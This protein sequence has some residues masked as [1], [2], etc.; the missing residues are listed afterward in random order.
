[1]NN[2]AI[3]KDL[4]SRLLVKEANKLLNERQIEL[5]KGRK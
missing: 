5:N 1:M 3:Q 2:E 4:I